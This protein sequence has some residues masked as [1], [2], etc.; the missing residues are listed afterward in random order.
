[1]VKK[2]TKRKTRWRTLS[3][4]DGGADTSDTGTTEIKQGNEKIFCSLNFV[5][6]SIHRRYQY[7]VNG[8]MRIRWCVQSQVEFALTFSPKKFNAKSQ[9]LSNSRE[10]LYYQIQ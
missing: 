5:V 6:F 9:T 2:A 3:I 7:T 4:G 8:G 1:M 10:F